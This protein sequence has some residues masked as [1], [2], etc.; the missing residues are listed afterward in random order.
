MAIDTCVI[1]IFVLFLAALGLAITLTQRLNDAN[2]ELAEMYSRCEMLKTH[3]EELRE[4]N[5]RLY[6]AAYVTR[7]DRHARVASTPTSC[8][9]CEGGKYA[10]AD[11]T[12]CLDCDGLGHSPTR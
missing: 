1:V 11:G 12:P 9:T 10:P 5:T 7:Q 2:E 3:N 8:V 4:Q 6:E